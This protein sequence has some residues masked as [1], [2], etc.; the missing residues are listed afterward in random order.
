MTIPCS[1]NCQNPLLIGTRKH[2]CTIHYVTTTSENIHENMS[3][4]PGW[5]VR[6]MTVAHGLPWGPPGIHIDGCITV[7]VY[8][9]SQR[10][11]LEPVYSLWRITTR[12]PL[13]VMFPMAISHPCLLPLINNLF[14]V[15]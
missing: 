12:A 13:L 3:K 1:F 9:P 7:Y 6:T 5:L 14:Y 4:S 2:I 11:A 15:I 8:I 10:E